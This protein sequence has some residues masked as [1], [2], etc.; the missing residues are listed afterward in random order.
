LAL[1]SSGGLAQPLRSLKGVA[2][3]EPSDLV[4]YVRDRGMLVVLGKALFWDMQAGSDGRTA[5][6]TCHFHAGADHRAHNQLSDPNHPFPANF[7]LYPGVFPLRRLTDPND[8]NSIVLQ[9]TSIRVGSAGLHRR[10][11]A[12]V[13]PGEAGEAGFDALDHPE[14]MIGDLQVRRVTAR[15]S[16]SVIN[17]VFY[18][19]GFWDGRASR[20]FNGFT[21]FGDSSPA[22]GGLASRGGALV[23]LP[24]RL[25]RA[26]L[27]SQA[28]GPIMDST[29]MSYEGRS[30]PRLARKL[31]SLAPLALQRVAPDDSVLGPM[32][33]IDGP[34]L[35][36]RY[37]YLSMIEAAFQPAFWESS[38]LVDSHGN[39]LG[40]AAG[41]DPAP[42]PGDGGSPREAFSQVEYNFSLF[43][44]LALLAY[45][46]TL[47]SD[48]SPFDRFMD[49]D[50]SALSSQEREGMVLFQTTG[51]CTRC[52]AGAEFSVATFSAGGN[53]RA[54]QRTGVRPAG[55]DAGSGN[56]AFKSVTL[57]NIELTGPYLHNGGQAT[58]EQ[59][60]DFYARG[61]DFANNSITP[62]PATPGQRAALAAFMRA[63]TDDRVRYERAPFDHPE[64]CVPAGHFELEPGRLVPSGS[65][66][67]PSS[68]ADRWRAIPAIG[69][70]G[71]AV[72]LQTFEELLG[73]IGADGSRAHA[74]T[75]ACTA[76]SVE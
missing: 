4:V 13:V 42:E 10:I 65:A 12:D 57:R 50:A 75:D 68:A 27:A 19:Q 67:F 5:C 66:M 35:A 61:G 32:A 16:P 47:V 14:F 15:N 59:V 37:T 31:L 28:V 49:G 9:D 46:S 1:L 69:A 62:F 38:Q 2:V 72:P 55:D 26:S 3:P 7:A 36:D 44:G 20:V 6:A 43:W 29:E 60:V 73:G 76:P 25:D 63:L 45:Q 58:I 56:G 53:R 54:F 8:R 17:A 34:G 23:R 51:R 11:L 39:L 41:P 74:L 70:G 48:D 52:H 21:P 33:R 22:P 71:N 64:L 18:Q 40:P 30:W 24:V